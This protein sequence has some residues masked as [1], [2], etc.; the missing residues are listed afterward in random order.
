MERMS[1]DWRES[2]TSDLEVIVPCSCVVRSMCIYEPAPSAGMTQV[3]SRLN[4]LFSGYITWQWQSSL[5]LLRIGALV[6]RSS[7]SAIELQ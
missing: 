4:G 7:R 1:G 6:T 3:K 2:V 5:A